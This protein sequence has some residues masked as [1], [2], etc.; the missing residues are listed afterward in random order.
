MCCWSKTWGVP[1]WLSQ[2]NGAISWIGHELKPHIVQNCRITLFYRRNCWTNKYVG[3]VKESHLPIMED[4]EARGKLVWNEWK[5]TR[6]LFP[7]WDGCL[8]VPTC[9]YQDKVSDKE[10]NLRKHPPNTIL[11]RANKEFKKYVLVHQK[12]SKS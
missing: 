9:P 10:G 5:T 12:F 7:F 6:I 2:R 3:L 11:R 1:S 4:I 8:M